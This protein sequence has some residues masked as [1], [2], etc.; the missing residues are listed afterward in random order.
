MKR[1]AREQLGDVSKVLLDGI[2]D[3]ESPLSKLH[4]HFY[5]MKDIWEM[6]TQDRFVL[7][8]QSQVSKVL[9]DGLYDGESNLSLLRTRQHVMK[10]VWE[11]LTGNWQIFLAEPAQYDEQAEEQAQPVQND[12]Q[13]EEQPDN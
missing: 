5:F 12:E 3:A 6:V 11:N 8:Q 4:G 9:L 10:K 2:Y 1:F 7:H 13:G